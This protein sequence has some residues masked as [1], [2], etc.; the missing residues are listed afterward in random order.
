MKVSTCLAWRSISSQASGTIGA[1]SRL[2]MSIVSTRRFEAADRQRAERGALASF[3][4]F[5][6]SALVEGSDVA[7]REQD[8]S[9]RLRELRVVSAQ[10]LER[11]HRVLDL[12]V[13]V[14]D[15]HALQRVVGA[16]LGALLIPI[17]RFE[18]LDQ[19]DDATMEIARLFRQQ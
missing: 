12:F 15:E 6:P 18:L 14:M 19:R 7:V 9:K 2:R 3:A 5:A 17:D 16:R 10:P 11:H 8:L 1:S 13:A 4:P